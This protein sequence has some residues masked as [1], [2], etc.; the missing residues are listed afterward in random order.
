[1]NITKKYYRFFISVF[2]FLGIL[3]FISCPLFEPP[4]QGD[5]G[6]GVFPLGPEIEVRQGSTIIWSGR[7]SSFGSVCINTSYNVTFTINNLGINNLN[8]MGVPDKVVKSGTDASSFTITSQP[9][10]SIF[11]NLLSQGGAAPY[12]EYSFRERGI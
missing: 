4:G 10:S 3:V 8:L 2:C 9:S 6:D 1:M 5:P 11:S 7:D 12:P